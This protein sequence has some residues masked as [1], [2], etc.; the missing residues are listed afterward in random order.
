[1]RTEN[2]DLKKCMRACLLARSSTALSSLHSYSH[3]AVHFKNVQSSSLLLPVNYSLLIPCI[4]R[5]VDKLANQ[6][7]NQLIIELINQRN[8]MAGKSTLLDAITSA[9]PKIASYAFTTIVPNLG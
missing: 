2:C 3:N 1:M 5:L 7:I 6:S 4:N 9:R 8:A